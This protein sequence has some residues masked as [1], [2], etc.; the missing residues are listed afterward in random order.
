MEASVNNKKIIFH[1]FFTIFFLLAFL[2]ILTSTSRRNISCPF[3]N[4]LTRHDRFSIHQ[5]W[6][7]LSLRESCTRDWC[8]SFFYRLWGRIVEE[9]SAYYRWYTLI[10]TAFKCLNFL[11]SLN[12]IGNPQDL[13]LQCNASMMISYPHN[14][15]RVC[16]GYHRPCEAC[17][18]RRTLISA[19]LSIISRDISK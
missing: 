19:F 15:I 8:V 16:S 17:I 14:F 6:L 18:R 10:D 9:G 2:I 7:M 11:M 5:K 3:P 12:I 1:Y 13:T 4:N